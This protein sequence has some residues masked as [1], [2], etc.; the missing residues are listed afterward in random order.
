MVPA[1]ENNDFLM[2]TKL[3]YLRYFIIIVL[4][5]YLILRETARSAPYV[6][7]KTQTQKF[8]ESF[9]MQD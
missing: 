2:R 4:N 3:G 8:G 5:F 7:Q 9:E 1:L 6:V